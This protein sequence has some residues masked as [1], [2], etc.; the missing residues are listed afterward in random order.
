MKVRVQITRG[1]IVVGHISKWD[2]CIVRIMDDRRK[3][4]ISALVTGASPTNR[5][6]AEHMYPDFYTILL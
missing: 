4:L 1:Q 3:F 5:G 2:P 6:R